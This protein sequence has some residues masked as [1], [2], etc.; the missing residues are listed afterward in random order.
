MLKAVGLR[1]DKRKWGV[2]MAVRTIHLAGG[3]FWGAE[4]YLAAI[5]GV[6]GTRVGYANGVVAGPTYEQVCTGATEAAETVAVRYDA[7]SLRLDELLALFFEVIDPVSVNRQGHDVG[8]QYRT[9]VFWSD[10]S[11]EPVVRTALDALAGLYPGQRIAVEALPLASFYDAEDYHQRY[12]EANPGGYCHIRPSA[13]A[14]V[15][16]RLAALRA[17]SRGSDRERSG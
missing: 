10:P 6:L 16:S 14:Q 17:R 8:T 9:G 12:L 1:T 13:I 7:D 11:D 4:R 15:P 5:P 3:C 2:A